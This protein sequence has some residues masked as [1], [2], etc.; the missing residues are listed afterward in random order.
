MLTIETKELE[1]DKYKKRKNLNLGIITIDL[2]DTE[3]MLLV[4]Q[5]ILQFINENEKSVS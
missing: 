3:D 4:Y 2:K 5:S 1:D